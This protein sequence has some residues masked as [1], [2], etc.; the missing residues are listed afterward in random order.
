VKDKRIVVTVADAPISSEFLSSLRRVTGSMRLL[1]E[2]MG[3]QRHGFRQQPDTFSNVFSLIAQIV[4][5]MLAGE[6]IL[7]T[8]S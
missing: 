4:Q 8:G 2:S 7:T 1:Q 5:L 6:I 3:S